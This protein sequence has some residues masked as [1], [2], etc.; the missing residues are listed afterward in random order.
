MEYSN[1]PTEC[2]NVKLFYKETEMIA[3]ERTQHAQ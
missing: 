2:G 1:A 3:I